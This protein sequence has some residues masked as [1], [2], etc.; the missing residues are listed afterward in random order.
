M[1][2]TIESSMIMLHH[3]YDPV[4]GFDPLI[5]YQGFLAENK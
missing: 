5:S 4:G 1:F 3:G 2:T